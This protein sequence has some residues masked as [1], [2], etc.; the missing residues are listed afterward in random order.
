MMAIMLADQPALRARVIRRAMLHPDRFLAAALAEIPDEQLAIAIGALPAVVWRLRLCSW[1]RMDRWA[2]D[3]EKLAALV[4]VRPRE[5]EVLL[6][7]VG[8]GSLARSG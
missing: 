6:R 2:A 5:L 8:I 1:P 4:D 7:Q 3:V